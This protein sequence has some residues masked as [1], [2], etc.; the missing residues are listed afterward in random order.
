MEQGFLGLALIRLDKL[1]AKLGILTSG[2]SDYH[3][4]PGKEESLGVFG[5][6]REIVGRIQT[7]CDKMR[8]EW[9]IE[10]E[11]EPEDKADENQEDTQ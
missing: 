4:E 2:G 7:Y 10:E 6:D 5:A 3:G 11:D 8:P 9:I 1:A